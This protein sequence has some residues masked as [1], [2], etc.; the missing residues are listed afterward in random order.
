M[1][2]VMFAAGCFWGVESAFQKIPGVMTTIVG[3][4]GGWT[5]NPGYQEVCSGTTGHAEVV[6]LIY[7]PRIVNFSLLLGVFW[8]IHDPR[9]LNRQGPDVGAQYRSAIFYY[10]PQQAQLA[11]T[12]KE[13]L[14]RNELSHGK[15]VTEI[16]P[17]KEFYRAEE[18]HQQYYQK[19]GIKI[20]VCAVLPR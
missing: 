14:E 17:A 20:P 9:S 18:Y 5:K 7:D 10:T 19:T 3:Y 8:R 15:I 11:R 13:K 16:L 1:E 6:Q 12:A 4:S 2:K